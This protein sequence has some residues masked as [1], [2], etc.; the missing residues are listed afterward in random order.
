MRGI[1]LF[2]VSVA[3]V[4][5][6]CTGLARPA[7]IFNEDDS[8]FF[9]EIA[10]ADE[11][12]L[13]AYIDSIAT[14]GHITHFF[15]CPN[16]MRAN[17]GSKVFE[18]AW[19]SCDV[20]GWRPT[21]WSRTLKKLNDMGVDP[22][23]VWA[24]RC[25]ERRIS[26]WLSMRM[27]DTHFVTDITYGG[28]S[29][30]WREHPEFW[31]KPNAKGGRWDWENRALDFA[32]VEVRKY[33][34]AFI[35]ELLSRYDVDGLECDWMRFPDHLT[36]GR[37]RE[38]S[39]CL[40]GFMRE[41][42]VLA[43]AAARR[44]GHPVRVGVR[45]DSDPEA[46]L[47]RGTD[48]FTWAREGSVDLVVPCNFWSSADFEMPIAEWMCRVREANPSVRVVPGIDANVTIKGQKQ[49]HLSI[50]EYCGWAH[51][52]YGQG[53]VGIYLFNLF[54]HPSTN[55]VWKFVIENGL[56]P[57][58]VSAHKKSIPENAV[59]ECAPLLRTK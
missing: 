12:E 5:I 46:A 45:V 53:A 1:H 47:A 29:R 57:D 48:V 11:N 19:A 37:E 55:G 30:F 14:N 50:D 42:R 24:K 44:L 15:M 54:T 2:I 35:E 28:H 22:Y 43:N 3:F 34:L 6:T 32:H 20:P 8:H 25:R 52:A 26:P 38:L 18:P 27:N 4:G 21:W 40:D 58:V 16:A 33:V 49:R 13:K 7:L 56:S 59:R 39:P 23:V 51:R 31:R 36:P 10:H 41:V 9:C 17:F